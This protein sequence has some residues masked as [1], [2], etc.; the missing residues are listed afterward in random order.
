MDEQVTKTIARMG[1]A[2]SPGKS[3]GRVGLAMAMKRLRLLLTAVT[4]S[5]HDLDDTDEFYEVD[6]PLG[7]ILKDKLYN[8][9]LELLNF[10]TIG[11]KLDTPG[12]AEDCVNTLRNLYY[13]F[14]YCKGNTLL[15]GFDGLDELLQSDF[16]NEIIVRVPNESEMEIEMGVYVEGKS[17]TIQVRFKENGLI[18][19]HDTYKDY[20]VFM[21]YQFEKTDDAENSPWTIRLKT[22]RTMQEIIGGDDIEPLKNDSDIVPMFG[23]FKEFS[24]HFLG[25]VCNP[26]G[27]LITVL[28][29]LW[30]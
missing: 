26:N 21:R 10:E 6:G 14:E 8:N 19:L 5:T 12:Y 2:P 27:A 24:K 20:Q 16:E 15:L 28:T 1:S 18:I 29:P 22:Q 23:T 17:L 4:T 13:K 30:K 9:F 7:K 11:G 25:G 3:E